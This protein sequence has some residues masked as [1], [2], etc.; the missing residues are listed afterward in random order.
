MAD[1]FLHLTGITKTYP[2]LVALEQV[3]LSVKH[4]YPEGIS[5]IHPDQ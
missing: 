3:S 4:Q 1:P 5:Q 2:G